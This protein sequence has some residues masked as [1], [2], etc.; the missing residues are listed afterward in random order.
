MLTQLRVL[1]AAAKETRTINEWKQLKRLNSLYA[2]SDLD[3]PDEIE[4]QGFK[5]D[6]KVIT[7]QSNSE[8]VEAEF[9][10]QNHESEYP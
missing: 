8:I 2:Y 7:E 10:S 5:Q 4:N 6:K 9:E 1:N 3:D